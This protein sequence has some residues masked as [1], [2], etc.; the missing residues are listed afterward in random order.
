MATMQIEAEDLERAVQAPQVGRRRWAVMCR[1]CAEDGRCDGCPPGIGR[2]VCFE[3]VRSLPGQF[4]P[5]T[6][7]ERVD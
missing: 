2:P 6:V 7:E 5:L 3:M 1:N 4:D